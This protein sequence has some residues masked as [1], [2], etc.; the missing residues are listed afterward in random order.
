MLNI[1]LCI[2][3][4]AWPAFLT[5]SDFEA[6]FRVRDG[7]KGYPGIGCDIAAVEMSDD[8]A[9]ILGL[10]IE[11][12]LITACFHV[13]APCCRFNLF[14]FNKLYQSKELFSTVAVRNAG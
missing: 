5:D 14:F 13:A 2:L 7:W 3:Q 10:K 11:G 8:F 6:F 9:R 12:L 4:K 1:D